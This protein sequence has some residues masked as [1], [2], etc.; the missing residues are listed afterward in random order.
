MKA[1]LTHE[2]EELKR[3]KAAKPGTPACHC[4]MCW[5][6]FQTVIQSNGQTVREWRGACELA[7]MDQL[8]CTGVQETQVR[9]D[10]RRLQVHSGQ[11]ASCLSIWSNI[12]KLCQ[13][14]LE[15]QSDCVIESSQVIPYTGKQAWSV[16]YKQA[17]RS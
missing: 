12:G 5:S 9:G 10:V 13:A 8:P 16:M 6:N 4:C 7:F 15:T 11:G 14:C 2:K 17:R 3:D 1:V